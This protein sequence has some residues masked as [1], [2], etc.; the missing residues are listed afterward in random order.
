MT[1]SLNIPYTDSE[2]TFELDPPSNIF[3]V[4]NAIFFLGGLILVVKAVYIQAPGLAI[5][6]ALISHFE[7]SEVK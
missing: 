4:V 5:L 2:I 6:G 1:Y 7:F 3:E